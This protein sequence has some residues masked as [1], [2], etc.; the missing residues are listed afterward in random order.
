MKVKK[1]F[2]ELLT[3]MTEE[4]L[5]EHKKR[6]EQEYASARDE[7]RRANDS[8][9]S[10]AV[11]KMNAVRAK[12]NSLRMMRPTEKIRADDSEDKKKEIL[13]RRKM[14][15]HRNGEEERRKQA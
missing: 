9:R 11:Q 7:V 15:V 2:E 14:H 3:E 13:A 6:L 12:L 8:E 10:R 5:K 1:L 4:E